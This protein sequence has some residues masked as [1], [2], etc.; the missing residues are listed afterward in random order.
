M[1]AVCLYFLFHYRSI[2]GKERVSEHKFQGS[3]LFIYLKIF[4]YVHGLNE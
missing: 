1:P 3:A 2:A 4:I